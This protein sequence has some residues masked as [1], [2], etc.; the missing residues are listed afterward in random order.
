MSRLWRVFPALTLVMFLTGCGVTVVD[1]TFDPDEVVI[2]ERLLL[3]ADE[4]ILEEEEAHE[5]LRD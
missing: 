5:G 1:G 4:E 2:D 3:E